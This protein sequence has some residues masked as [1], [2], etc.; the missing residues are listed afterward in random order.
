MRY[1]SAITVLTLVSWTASEAWAQLGLYGSPG[2]VDLPP[3]GLQAFPEDTSAVNPAEEPAYLMHEAAVTPSPQRPRANRPRLAPPRGESPSVVDQM[4]EESGGSPRL[5]PQPLVAEDD[6]TAVGGYW[7]DYGSEFIDEGVDGYGDPFLSFF[8]WYVRASGLIMARDDPN[9]VWFTYQSG[10]N[11]DQLMSSDDIDL[12]WRGGGEI[13]FGRRFCCGTW[14]LE[15]G[16]WTLDPFEGLAIQT[17]PSGVATPLDFTD[18]VF[19]DGAMGGSPVDLFDGAVEHRLWR[20][21]ELHNV[22]INVI[23]SPID[24]QYWDCFD[25]NWAVGAR[26]FRFAENLRF[27]SLGAGG[28]AFGVDPTLEGYLEDDIENNLIGAQL[29]CELGYRRGDW[30]LY[31]FP[32]VGVYGNHI[33][34]RFS[35]YRGDGALFAP[36]P[37]T[38][39]LYPA[40]SD[41]GVFSFLTE[42]DL[43]LQWQFTPRW[44]AHIG[45][46]VLVATGM[47]LA[48]HQ[49]PFYIVDTPEL[50][51]INHNG[52]LVLHGGVAGVTFSF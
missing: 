46:R 7:A 27:G 44:G 19:A 50:V 30:R 23:H 24:L 25:F 6:P 33:R 14:A 13:R 49:I 16:Y 43:G 10:V 29:G 38:Y 1:L 3:A 8:P 15:A 45:Y 12:E 34:H 47:G 28:V 51:D 32:K 35:A 21:D 20:T 5:E 41:D 39:P 18:V 40:A 4:L 37:A 31:L 36:A 52:Q 42:V 17:H 26:Y 2:M 9:R 22:E 48:D 11:E